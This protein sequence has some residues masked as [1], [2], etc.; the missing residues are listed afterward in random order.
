MYSIKPPPIKPPASSTIS[1]SSIRLQDFRF[2]IIGYYLHPWQ[3]DV[4]VAVL[5][6]EHGTSSLLPRV[7]SDDL[8]ACVMSHLQCHALLSTLILQLDAVTL[9]YSMSTQCSQ[10]R[11]RKK[12][13]EKN[14]TC[15][16][17][18]GIAAG[19]WGFVKFSNVCFLIMGKI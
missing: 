3:R 5:R 17:L 14:E 13:W 19:W 18:R 11:K 2:H 16:S 8:S 9:V 15:S 4:G 7:S 12:W 6:E 10:K 1:P